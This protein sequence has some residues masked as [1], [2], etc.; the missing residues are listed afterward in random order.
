MGQALRHA[1]TEWKVDIITMSFG[2]P[3]ESAP[4]C[5][6]LR[7]AI[8]EAHASRVLMFAAASNTG[9]H[10]PAPAFPAR[11]S[12]VFCIYSG[13]GMGNRAPT[14]PTARPHAHNFLTLGEA[15]ESAWPRALAPYPWKKRK[16]GTSFATPVAAGIA[17]F[18]MLYAYQNLPQEKARRF[19]EYDKMREWL[20]HLSNERA[21]YNVLSVGNFFRRSTEERNIVLASL[22]DGKPLKT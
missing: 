19:K 2:F 22:L 8:H 17:A 3:D 5:A 7:D 16:S 1:T 12:N 18:L 9:A 20:F 11:L 15:V 4:S 21:G 6:D 13:D 14:T 10:S